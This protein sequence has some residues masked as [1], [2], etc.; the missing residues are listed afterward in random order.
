VTRDE[1]DWNVNLRLGQF[2]LK[3]E[4]AQSR[5]SDIEYDAAR[6]L[7]TLVG[8]VTVKVHRHNVMK[9][10]EARSLADLVRMAE[11]LRIPRGK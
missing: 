7:G 9:K 1:N 5:Q 11:A 10:L 2:G 4:P 8:Q 3:I 6:L